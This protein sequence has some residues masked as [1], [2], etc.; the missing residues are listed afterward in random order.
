MP[1]QAATL[2]SISGNQPRHRKPR[3]PHQAQDSGS[4][5]ETAASDDIRALEREPVSKPFPTTD[6]SFY[7]F[8]D[9]VERQLDAGTRDILTGAS[10]SV[11]HDELL[12]EIKQMV[13]TPLTQIT[14]SL[15]QAT[16]KIDYTGT[17]LA[18]RMDTMQIQITTLHEDMSQ[19]PTLRRTVQDLERQHHAMQRDIASGQGT[20]SECLHRTEAME[21]QL[22]GMRDDH[23]NGQREQHIHASDSMRG[24]L[25]HSPTDCDTHSPARHREGDLQPLTDEAAGR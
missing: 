15:V 6:S 2:T 5:G 18:D 10:T 24:P 11:P 25:S 19:F 17:I 21:D 9:K 20:I 22:R 12:Q 14:Y 1:L 23:I 13:T 8:C 16:E 4:D 3:I 7:S